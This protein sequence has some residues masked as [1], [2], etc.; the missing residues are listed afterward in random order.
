MKPHRSLLEENV[1]WLL[2]EGFP[3]PSGSYLLASWNPY[4]LYTCHPFLTLFPSCPSQTVIINIFLH[5][6]TL[7]S[8]PSQLFLLVN[9]FS[10]F[11]PGLPSFPPCI[12][13]HSCLAAVLCESFLFFSFTFWLSLIMSLNT[14]KKHTHD[15]C[16]GVGQ[17]MEAFILTVVNPPTAG[18]Q[19]PNIPS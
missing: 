4:V 9:S 11:P 18:I 16:H 14:N 5:L 17:L 6:N 2:T 3:R 1:P 15:G 12:G 10:L 7:L 19:V 13:G 8:L